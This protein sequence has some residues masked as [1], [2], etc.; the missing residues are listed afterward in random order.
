MS[1]CKHREGVITAVGPDRLTIRL[2]RKDEAAVSACGSCA[3]K[4]LCHSR[5][6]EGAELILRTTDVEGRR[7]GDR[8][9]LAYREANPALAAGILFLP[10]LAGLMTGGFAAERFFGQ[11]NGTF[12]CG[13]FGGFLLGLA[14][15]FGVNRLV[16]SLRP[17]AEL[18]PE[19]E[20]GKNDETSF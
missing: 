14:I 7:P 13:A 11:G 19:K 5:A 6:A 8:V 9:R 15:T 1:N 17:K 16:P 10:A 4:S 12:L 20:A 18:L 3:M 2:D